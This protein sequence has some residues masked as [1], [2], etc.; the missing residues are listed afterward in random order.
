MPKKKV[1]E[2]KAKVKKVK[3]ERGDLIKKIL[4]DP[5]LPAYDDFIVG[6]RDILRGH[7]EIEQAYGSEMNRLNIGM[8]GLMEAKAAAKV[9]AKG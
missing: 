1:V 8:T 4:D 6:G 3:D 9:D 7:F 2:T 5:R